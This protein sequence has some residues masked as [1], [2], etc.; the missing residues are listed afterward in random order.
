LDGGGKDQVLQI[1]AGGKRD[2]SSI[3]LPFAL[4]GQ[5][6]KGLIKADLFYFSFYLPFTAVIAAGDYIDK[7][8]LIIIIVHSF[9]SQ[10]IRISFS[11]SK[12]LPVI[13]I[14][15]PCLSS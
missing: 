4:C 10:S 15:T 8:G 11:I 3:R 9:T 14:C 12:L 6:G 13:S 7:H 2:Q 1:T 5:Y